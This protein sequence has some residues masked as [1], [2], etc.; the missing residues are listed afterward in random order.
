[1]SGPGYISEEEPDQCELCGAFEERRPYGPNGER[2][3]FDCAMK[4]EEA[5]KRQFCKQVLGESIQ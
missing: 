4:D 1:M 2:V 5:A 3:C